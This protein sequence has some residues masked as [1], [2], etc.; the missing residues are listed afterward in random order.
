MFAASASSD[1]DKLKPREPTPIPAPGGSAKPVMRASAG[2]CEVCAYR[3][4]RMSEIDGLKAFAPPVVAPVGAAALVSTAGA[5]AAAAAVVV[6]SAGAAATGIA[7]D[8]VD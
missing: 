6:S 4:E 8:G 5:G 7:A 2:S 3:P 1:S